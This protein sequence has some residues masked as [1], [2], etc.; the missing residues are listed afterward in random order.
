MVRGVTPAHKGL[1]PSRLITYLS[2]DKKMPMLG[3]HS[4][5]AR[6]G[7]RL[8]GKLVL[9]LENLCLTEKS[10]I[11]FANLAKRQNVIGNCSAPKFKTEY[12]Q[13][14][15]FYVFLLLTLNFLVYSIA[16]GL[17]FAKYQII[18]TFL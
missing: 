17:K 12:N 16:K 2:V 7:F 6:S 13:M 4:R 14:I 8:N 9:Y 15:I 11:L 1:A 18:F 10:R 3:A 5:L